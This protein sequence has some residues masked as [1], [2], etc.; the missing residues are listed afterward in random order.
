MCIYDS[1]SREWELTFKS[2]RVHDRPVVV[3][4]VVDVRRLDYAD[5]V[6][7]LLS[8]VTLANTVL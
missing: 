5:I 8:L 4:N 2:I 7:V 6:I 3:V 1:N